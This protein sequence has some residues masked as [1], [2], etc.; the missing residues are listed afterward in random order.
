MRSPILPGIALVLFATACG[1][2]SEPA[3]ETTAPV[4]EAPEP[5]P[6]EKPAPAPEAMAFK[7]MN[8]EQRI[9]FMKQTVVPAM[10]TTFQEFDSKKFAEFNCKTCH[11]A[12][13]ADG[14]FKMPNPGLPVLPSM[15]KFMAFAKDPKHEPWVK[16]MAEKVKP[17]MAK[18]LQKSEFDPQTNTGEF[19]CTACHNMEGGGHD[20]G[21]HAH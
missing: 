2:K 16:F 20:A 18:L 17:Q 8:H 6:V 21:K 1:G 14:T 15:D 13:A 10:K 9:A 11:G 7:D 12:G 4:A 3:T 19:G 5:V